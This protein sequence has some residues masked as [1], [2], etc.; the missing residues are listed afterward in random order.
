FDDLSGGDGG[1]RVGQDDGRAVRKVGRLVDSN[2]LDADRPLCLRHLLDVTAAEARH[3]AKAVLDG[4]EGEEIEILE[5]S[6][7]AGAVVAAEI[8]AL[9]AKGRSSV[10]GPE[11]DEGFEVH[12]AAV[13]ADLDAALGALDDLD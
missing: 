12:A 9:L 7:L 1:D 4:F 6:D 3:V 10:H 5:A 2:L 8:E 11:L 13:V